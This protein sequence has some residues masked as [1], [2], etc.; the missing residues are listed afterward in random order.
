M[1]RMPNCQLVSAVHDTLLY[2]LDTARIQG[3]TITITDETSTGSL[4][5]DRSSYEITGKSLLMI[6]RWMCECVL[7]C[8]GL[9]IDTTTPDSQ[10]SQNVL[11]VATINCRGYTIR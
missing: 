5:G 4:E 6:M 9:T 1:A 3:D 2:S 11:L 8:H 7:Y 10:S